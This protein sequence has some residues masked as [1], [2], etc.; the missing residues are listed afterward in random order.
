MKP[1]NQIL[2]EMEWG[3]PILPIVEDPE[4]EAQ[5]VAEIGMLPDLLKRLSPSPW[6]RNALLRW[7]RIPITQ[8]PIRLRDIAALVTAQEN[9]CRYCYGVA[10]SQMKFFGYSEKMINNI[11]REMQLAEMDEKDRCYIQFCRNLARSN[12]RP[13]KIDR[14]KL[15]E[16]GFTELQVAEIA[17]LITNHCF[18]NRVAT[19][20]SCYPMH[21][22]ENL[23]SSFLGRI[24]RPLI[25]R[26]IRRLSLK[27]I[28]EL[29]NNPENFHGVVQA[30]VGLPAAPMLNEA[31]EGAFN[32]KV[33]STE[34]KILMFAVVAHSLDCEFCK[35]ETRNMSILCGFTE[36][37]FD[38]SLYSL[39][40]SKLS[41]TESKILRWTRETVHF[42]TGPIQKQIRALS[43]E[44]DSKVLLEAIG[45]AALA[46]TTV[47]LGMLLE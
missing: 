2:N 4:W 35:A 45:V 28:S 27:Q 11:E 19:F 22:L 12:P 3:D 7:D 1:M 43:Q 34:L 15:I 21:K 13:A 10:R 6:L 26:K 40:S 23:V 9:A 47:R 41:E 14:D 31:L 5:V 25:A 17:F 37:E 29:P 33:L 20:I 32:S 18:M 36:K 24:L 30:L 44:V 8:I 42:Q 38:S 46:N 39:T 16:F